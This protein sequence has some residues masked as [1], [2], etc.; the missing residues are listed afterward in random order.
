MNLKRQVKKIFNFILRRKLTKLI[1][2]LIKVKIGK[3]KIL[4]P[5]SHELPYSLEVNPL[6]D[7]ALPRICTELSK[8]GL[9]PKIIDIGANIGDTV[10]LIMEK[11][12]A[13]FLCID[14]NEEFFPLLK[15]NT[16]R[17][18]KSIVLEKTY[19]GSK[20]QV[21]KAKI[22]ETK[23]TARLIKNESG[24][25]I[26]ITTLDNLT[27]KHIK[28]KTSDLIKID[29]DG[30]EQ[31]I[32]K[33]AKE[34]LNQGRPLLFFEFTPSAMIEQG[35]N[36]MDIFEYIQKFGYT[37]ALFYTNFGE[38]I[39]IISTKDKSKINS[40]IKNID[41]IT[42]HYYDILAI[43]SEKWKQDLLKKELKTAKF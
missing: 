25:T 30:F 4:M 17:Y 13:E 42:V 35:E 20:K 16:Q 15:Q 31:T 23:G 28:F 6:Y 18:G 1:D 14:G 32:L 11:T 19:L 34:T 43:N 40:L 10:A 12:N 5:L 8:K 24:K 36:P 26:K 2:P 33:G 41:N 27:K 29:T 9:N 3:Y 7:R 38:A 39:S 21:I 22:N 37:K